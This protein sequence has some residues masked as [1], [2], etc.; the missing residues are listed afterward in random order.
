MY[1]VRIESGSPLAS[2]GTNGSRCGP[3][4]L[5]KIGVSGTL[6]GEQGW[7]K[8]TDE[9]LWPFLMRKKIEN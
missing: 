5:K 9:N 4:I 6:Y 2:A 1:P 7:N 8:I 3:E